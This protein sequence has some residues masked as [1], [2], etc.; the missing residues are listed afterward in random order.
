[1]SSLDSPIV[2]INAVGLTSQWLSYAP[3]LQ[4][5]AQKQGITRL[6]EVWPA[7]TCTAQATLL[8]GKLPSGHGIVGNG[9]LFRDTGEV[10]FWQQSNRLFESE[11]V[12]ETAS[13]RAQKRG[14]KFRTSK[15]FW[16]FN[17]GANVDFSLTPKPWYGA[18]GN[19]RFGITGFPVSFPDEVEKAVGPFPFP[20]FW[21]PKAG[22]PSTDWIA[23]AAAWHLERDRPDLMFVYLPHLDYEPQRFGPSGSDMPR[24]MGE[25]DGCVG[26]LLK[27]CEK[28]GARP[29]IVSEYGHLDTPNHCLPNRELRRVGL[30]EVRD[31]PFGE[32][33]DTFL[34]RAFAVVDHQLAHV[35]VREQKDIPLVRDILGVLPGVA[36]VLIGPERETIGLDHP[37]SGEIILVAEG[38]SW[39]AYPYWLDDK[40]APD[41]ARTID[42]HRKPGYD[43]C[44]LFVNPR[45]FLPMVR[46][47]RKLA[48]KKFGFRT[49]FDIIPLDPSL[50]RGSHGIACPN[51][52]DQPVWIGSKGL[53]DYSDTPMTAFR[54]H[55]LA[56]LGLSDE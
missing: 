28:V 52:L 42:I 29:W 55:L 8:T 20:S 44:E 48:A 16:W 54:N 9:W 37:R 3:T 38:D 26:I 19:K 41:F 24:L 17:Q 5:L 4:K 39:F 53:A 21:G 11:P 40:R 7:V 12:Y 35:Y 1:M 56:G 22:L 6:G 51:P 50:V 47:L 25:L 46:I 36:K 34:S 49:L 30:L 2:V 10:R 45:I 14:R 33:L 15:I 43:P 27:A 32:V 31:G 13:K 23:Q 18:D